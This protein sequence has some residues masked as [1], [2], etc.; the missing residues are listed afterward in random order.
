MEAKPTFEQAQLHLQVYEQ[1]REERLRRARE[2]MFQNYWPETFEDAMKVTAPGTDGGA[3]FMMVV[4]Y[5]E[6]ACALLDYGLLHEELFFETSGEFFGLF[7]RIRPV[8]KQGRDAWK[9]PYFLIHMENAAKRF[10]AWSEKRSPGQIATMRQMMS[11][12]PK[13]GSKDQGNKGKAA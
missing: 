2:W 9:N 7:E 3:N 6:Q 12:M 13:P 1:R 5:W 10:E 11:Q 4:S 8:L